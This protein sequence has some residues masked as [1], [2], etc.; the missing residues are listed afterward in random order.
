MTTTTINPTTTPVPVK[1]EGQTWDA[2]TEAIKSAVEA[3]EARLIA[4]YPTP[5]ITAERGTTEWSEQYF[6]QRRASDDRN[7][8]ISRYTAKL[9]VS[10]GEALDALVPN[11]DALRVEYEGSG[12]QGEGC[13]FDVDIKR[14]P[15]TN[16]VVPFEGAK[17]RLAYTNDENQAWL[18][19]SSDALALLPDD[20]TEWL[21][22]T[23]WALAYSIHPGFEIDAGGFGNI[24][25]QRNADG[26]MKLTLTHADR[27]ESV[28]EYAPQE[29]A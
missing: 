7:E 18:Q 21:D 28:E 22:E 5:A 15:P 16:T 11:F 25:V 26:E 29:L 1:T 8:I 2:F 13:T 23:C 24:T 3:E 6:S 10:V 4:E 12:D 19:A 27:I 20:L 17:P 9:I 14:E